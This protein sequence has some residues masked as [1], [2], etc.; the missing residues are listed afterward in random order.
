MEGKARSLD[1]ESV[2]VCVCVCGGI[3]NILDGAEWPSSAR[4]LSQGRA[5]L[6][7]QPS[8]WYPQ[9]RCFNSLLLRFLVNT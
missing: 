4:A 9:E 8:P 3:P 6:T 1:K 2:C 5:G 7:C